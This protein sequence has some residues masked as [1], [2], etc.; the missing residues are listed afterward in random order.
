MAWSDI[1]D[2]APVS[3]RRAAD[4]VASL[5]T[6]PGVVSDDGVVAALCAAE[7]V[8]AT[9]CAAARIDVAGI[10]RSLARGELM[11]TFR[12]VER[13]LIALSTLR[14]HPDAG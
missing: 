7:G 1:V 10:R 3:A 6:M 5:A 8:A 2:A 11:C 4:V 14:D 9:P 12:R 13:A